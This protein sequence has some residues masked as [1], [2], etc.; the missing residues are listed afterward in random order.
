MDFADGMGEVSAYEGSEVGFE[1]P[2][3]ASVGGVVE[4]GGRDLEGW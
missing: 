2:I 3:F 1:M 4:A